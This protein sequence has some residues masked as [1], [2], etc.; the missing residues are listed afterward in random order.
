MTLTFLSGN[1][2]GEKYCLPGLWRRGIVKTALMAVPILRPLA[3]GPFRYRSMLQK[4]LMR[5][6]PNK[7]S[8]TDPVTAFKKAP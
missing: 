1:K 6:L 8:I 2:R 7:G 3:F 5:L 4:A